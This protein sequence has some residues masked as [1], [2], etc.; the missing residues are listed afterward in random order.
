MC[1]QHI[2]ERAKVNV[3][4]VT[5]RPP[6]LGHLHLKNQAPPPASRPDELVDCAGVDCPHPA[7]P[8]HDSKENSTGYHRLLEHPQH[9]CRHR[10]TGASAESRVG[11][12]V[13]AQSSLLLEIM[14]SIISDTCDILAVTSQDVC[15]EKGWLY[16][17][18][19]HPIIFN[20]SRFC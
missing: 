5:Q 1:V 3:H 19:L 9:G 16:R 15:C 18:S 20:I 4:D 14:S 12:V 10:M 8:A 6:P 7:A 13:L 11:S 2:M 17:Q